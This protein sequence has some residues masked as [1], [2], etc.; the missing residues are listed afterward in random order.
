MSFTTVGMNWPEGNLASHLL[1]NGHRGDLI[2]PNGD[3]LLRQPA[4]RAS[5]RN[6]LANIN[7]GKRVTSKARWH[8]NRKP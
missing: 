3:R 5:G 4:K 2:S 1:C 7:E 6:G 8:R